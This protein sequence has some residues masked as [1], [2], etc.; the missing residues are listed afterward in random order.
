MFF[1]GHHIDQGAGV[2]NDQSEND[3]V[4]RDAA[5]QGGAPETEAGF[6]VGL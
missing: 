3:K 6:K 4:D 1:G 2:E 5:R